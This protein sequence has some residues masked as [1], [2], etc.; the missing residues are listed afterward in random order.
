MTARPAAIVRAGVHAADRAGLLAFAM[1]QFAF[2]KAL[3]KAGRVFA[4]HRLGCHMEGDVRIG[5][6][7]T[8]RFPERVRIGS[9]TALNGKIWI[10]AWGPVSIGARCLFNDDISLLTAGHDVHSPRFEGV[11]RS[12]VIGDYVWLPCRIVV[13][14][15]VTIGHAAVVGTGSIVTRDVPAYAI[16]AGNPARVVGTRTRAEF[17]YVPSEM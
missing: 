17:E 2:R 5:P 8:M 10:D 7:V 1:R 3:G 15:G 9:G 6:E 12:I 11:T 4:W 14:P 16:V 13:L